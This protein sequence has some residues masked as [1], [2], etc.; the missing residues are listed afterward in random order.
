MSV[1]VHLR[2]T[3]RAAPDSIE[4]TDFMS[5]VLQ[6]RPTSAAA[7][8]L[9]TTDFMSAEVQFRPTSPGYLSHSVLPQES[10]LA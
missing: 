5:V 9:E 10:H 4:T 1:E 6:F 2:P 3:S 8:D 7:N